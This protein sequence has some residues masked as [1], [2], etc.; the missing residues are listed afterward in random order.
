MGTGSGMDLGGAMVELR[1]HHQAMGGMLDGLDEMMG[2]MDGCMSGMHGG[3]GGSG[4]GM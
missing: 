1:R 4:D 2:G 3:G